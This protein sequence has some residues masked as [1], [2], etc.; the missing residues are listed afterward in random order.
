[1]KKEIEKATILIEALPYI[2]KFYNKTI[3]IKYGG[4]SMEDDSLRSSFA[5]DIVL[6]KYVGIN[7]I[8]VHGG[9]PQIESLLDRLNI[10]TKFVSGLRVTDERTMEVVEMVLSGKINK[11]IV[12]LINKSGAKAV[13][14]SGKDGLLIRVK[15]SNNLVSKNFDE[16]SKTIDLGF[17][18]EITQINTEIIKKIEDQYIPVIAP[19]GVDD[20]FITY[21]INADLAAGHIAAA[22]KASKLITLTDVK[23]LLD[24]DGKLIS[25]LKLDKLKAMR[26]SN[27][28]KTGMIPKIDSIIYALSHGVSNAHII[29]GTILHS[30][31]LELFTDRGIGTQI[32][33]I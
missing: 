30:V 26:H 16:L 20:S 22:L 7:V 27:F 12:N 18:G 3:V 29:N 2:R 8:I 15:K 23:G 25:T 11:D 4:S 21:N 33:G 19:I 24:E 10:E 6:L 5:R 13:G 1:M 14:F 28:I 31:L 32:T 17:V 9:G